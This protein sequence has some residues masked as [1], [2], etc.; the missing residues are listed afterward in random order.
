MRQQKVVPGLAVFLALVFLAQGAWSQGGD[1]KE[2]MKQRLPEI[3]RMKADGV[4]GEN[5]SGYLELVPG[6]TGSQA[7]VDQENSDRKAVYEAIA[8]QQGV[9]L[10]KV[11]NLRALQIFERANPGEYLKSGDGTWS[12]K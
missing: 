6:K 1:I 4:V 11:E 8:A 12:R 3:V 7:L 2:R 9:S 5:A 10:G